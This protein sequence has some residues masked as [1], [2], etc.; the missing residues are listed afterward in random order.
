MTDKPTYRIWCSID[1]CYLTGQEVLFLN[2]DSREHSRNS[3]ERWKTLSAAKKIIERA[4]NP[5]YYR[6][7]SALEIHKVKV[8][9]VV[10]EII[11]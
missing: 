1:E 3:K 10:E 4:G 2:I 6:E 5:K 9:E 11:K 8:I 7:L